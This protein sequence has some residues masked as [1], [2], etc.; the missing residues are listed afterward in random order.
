MINCI[1][2][3]EKS[4]QGIGFNGQMPWPRLTGDMRWFREKTTNQIVIM[5]RKTWES[6]GSKNLPNR[7]NIVISR[8]F[9]EEA[10]RCFS[11]TDLALEFCTT[12]YPHKE[13]FIIGGSTIYQKY[14]NIVDR[15]YITEIDADY[16]CDTFFDMNYV[17]E[18]F[19]KI[20]EH[21][22]FNEPIKYT[23]KEYNA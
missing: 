10:D 13:I 18:N 6:I 17:Q 1:V 7:I 23:I 4:L 8:N 5:G 14:L 19:T 16:K 12:V 22:T 9:I 2:A 11:D 15:F 20:K 3:V 21:A